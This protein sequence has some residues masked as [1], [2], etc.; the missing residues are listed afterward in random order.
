MLEMLAPEAEHPGKHFTAANKLIVD[1]AE[2]GLNTHQL[3]ERLYF[4]T[5][6]WREKDTRSAGERFRAILKGKYA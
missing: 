6:G 5:E 2:A 4:L 3:M 1:L